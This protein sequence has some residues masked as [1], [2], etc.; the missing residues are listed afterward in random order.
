[1]ISTVY[2]SESS[3]SKPVGTLDFDCDSLV[4]TI[5]DVRVVFGDELVVEHQATEVVAV[6]NLR[7][8]IC[9][10]TEGS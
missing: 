6:E 2:F 1:M 8:D 7:G 3:H 4:V 10:S 9:E 5:P